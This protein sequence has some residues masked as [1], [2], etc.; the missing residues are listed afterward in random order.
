MVANRPCGKLLTDIIHQNGIN[1]PIMRTKLVGNRLE[2]YLYGGGCV[3]HDLASDTQLPSTTQHAGLTLKE[4]HKLAKAKGIKGYSS[5]KK[6][7]LVELLAK[8]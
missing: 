1:V 4:L 3:V 2:L 7:V 6:S 8:V 5:M